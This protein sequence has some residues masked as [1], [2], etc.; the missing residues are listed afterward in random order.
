MAV[1][2]KPLVA[3]TTLSMEGA[4]GASPTLRIKLHGKEFEHTQKVY[5]EN[6]EKLLELSREVLKNAD[7]DV[8]SYIEDIYPLYRTLIDTACGDGASG[9]VIK[10]IAQ[11]EHIETVDLITRLSPIV[12]WIVDEITGALD[13]LT[14]Q[15]SGA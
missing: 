2:I 9:R 10:W 14:G 11:G 5:T 8:S 7:G 1:V 12:E 4:K 15:D 13:G 3:T 6:A